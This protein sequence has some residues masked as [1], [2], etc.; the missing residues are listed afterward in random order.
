MSALGLRFAR[1]VRSTT[2]RF[3]AL[4]AICQL[5]SALLIFT[6]I[7]AATDR[8]LI[9][10]Y[11]QVVQE[12]QRNL[13]A[14]FDEGGPALT[15]K[16]INMILGGPGR[17]DLLILLTDPRRQPLAGNLDAWPATIKPVGEWREVNL[18]RSGH[19]KPEDFS[20]VAVTLP[21]GH[22]LL[23]GHSLSERARTQRVL[24]V[25]L[26]GALLLG[27]P[28]GLLGGSILAH[29]VSR[30]IGHIADVAADV[31]SGDLGQRITLSGSGDIF[32]R[33]SSSLNA[34][35]ARIEMLMHELQ[36]LA[37][38]LAHD[39]RSPVTRMHARAEQALRKADA[40][41]ARAAMTGVLAECEV[42]LRTLNTVLQISRAD[43]GI[44]KRAHEEFDLAEMVRSLCEMYE[45]LAEEA[46]LSIES[47]APQALM[48][49][50][51]RQLISQ[52]LDNLIGN[53]FKYASAG[54]L[55]RLS[56]VDYGDYVELE[57]ADHGPG[58]PP[59]LRSEALK[60]FGRLDPARSTDG[61]GLGLAL[62]A[63][64]ARLH[65]GT[66]AIEDNH[67]GLR[68]ILRLPNQRS[69][70][71]GRQFRSPQAAG[72]TEEPI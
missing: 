13:V 30:R 6:F 8:L 22:H 45:P 7:Y 28:V 46:A 61:A 58:I 50:G 56:A 11:Q 17:R 42:L 19:T 68:V 34:M 44:G 48:F 47:S 59:E 62:V 52:A 69:S 70:K 31:S 51:D 37:D 32:D 67:P 35:L 1:L 60:Q 2:T 3:L 40:P 10:E 33:L 12:E 21:Q 18:Y 64:V 65:D 5:V 20:V 38:S 16:V 43:A 15:A 53:A 39:L 26:V 27:V 66:V 23:I 49:V 54:K 71:E 14:S 55:I 41:E 4:H 36:T 29:W 25:A 63:A 9:S 57:A 72:A 24:N